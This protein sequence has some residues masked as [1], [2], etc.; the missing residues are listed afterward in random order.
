MSRDAFPNLLWFEREYPDDR[1]AQ[2]TVNN[3]IA[4]EPL[5]LIAHVVR[6]DRPFTEILTA[7]YTMANGFSAPSMIG[8]PGVPLRIDENPER[9]REVKIP[10]I[11]HAGIFTSTMFLNRFPTSDTNRNRHRSRMVYQF[12][13]DIDINAF[14]SRPVDVNQ[15]EGDNPT[16]NNPNCTICH[17]SMDPV[18]GLFKN[19]DEQGVYLGD[20]SW[21]PDDMLAPDSPV[22][23]CHRVNLATRFSGL[24]RNS[25]LILVSR[26]QSQKRFLPRSQ[27][28]PRFWNQSRSRTRILT[29]PRRTLTL[30]HACAPTIRSSRFS[31]RSPTGSYKAVIDLNPGSRNRIISYFRAESALTADPERLVELEPFGTAK[32][33]TPEKLNRKIKSVTGV[34]WR[35]AGTSKIISRTTIE[36]YGG[37]DSDTVTK[38]IVEPNGVMASLAQ[39]MAYEV[40]CSAVSF[41]FSKPISGRLLFQDVELNTLPNDRPDL[42]R[43]Q[44]L[45]LHSRIL[46]RIARSFRR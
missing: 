37:I 24:R 5:E 21:Y 2:T 10:G 7:D 26:Q 29:F 41:D 42:I 11:P 36:F 3:A 9:F 34:P 16:L 33:L 12:F 27:G 23:R 38:R 20:D 6:E 17:T 46:R 14:G 45:D 35:G 43:Q 22:N 13:L 4:R 19:W 31:K 30:M 32:L 40:S 44:I 1:K 28:M 18:A 8:L 39:R 25:P 15:V